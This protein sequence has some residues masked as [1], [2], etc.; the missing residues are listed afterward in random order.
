MHF[1]DAPLTTAEIRRLEL[2]DQEIYLATHDP[3]TRRRMHERLKELEPPAELCNSTVA[4]TDIRRI[5]ESVM[6]T[7]QQRLKEYALVGKS[8][9]KLF[10]AELHERDME[11]T[12]LK[13]RL[14]ELEQKSER[15]NG[16]S[17]AAAP[18]YLYAG[19]DHLS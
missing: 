19:V 9:V 3:W 18:A 2:S 14:A 4:E 15:P 12:A 16:K 11:I 5:A 7:K 1:K 13:Q 6:L 8:L 17:T 10:R